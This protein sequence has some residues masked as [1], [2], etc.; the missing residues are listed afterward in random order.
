[1][2]KLHAI[3][4]LSATGETFG[5]LRAFVAELDE[6][7]IDDAVVLLDGPPAGAVPDAP[8]AL[9]TYVG[10]RDA[11][12]GSLR[13]WVGAAHAG[14]LADTAPVH[15][16]ATLAV[17]LPVSCTEIGSCSEHVEANPPMVF[18]YIEDRCAGHTP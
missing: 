18:A 14:A 10:G 12:V 6:L 3:V 1:M 8:E 5:A 4:T 7:R 16:L 9:D 15:D 11:T 13:A 17:D 2:S